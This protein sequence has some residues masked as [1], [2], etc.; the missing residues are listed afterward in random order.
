M[1]KA[2]GKG[3][4]IFLGLC[5]KNKLQLHLNAME[6]YGWCLWESWIW[7][8]TWNVGRICTAEMLMWEKRLT[9]KASTQQEYNRFLHKE[10][11]FPSSAKHPFSYSSSS[12]DYKGNYKLANNLQIS[13][14]FPKFLDKNYFTILFHITHKTYMWIVHE[15]PTKHAFYS[16]YWQPYSHHLLAIF[17]QIISIHLK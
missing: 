2:S 9:L 6:F 13:K 8:L 7:M 16:F 15:T 5:L 11:S 3:F 12:Y 4:F 14:Q 1:D 17:L 10:V